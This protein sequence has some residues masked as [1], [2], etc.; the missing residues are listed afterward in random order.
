MLLIIHEIFKKNIQFLNLFLLR[1]F[2]SSCIT[3]SFHFNSLILPRVI[4]TNITKCPSIIIVIDSIGEYYIS[5]RL[6]L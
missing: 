3:S 5:E 4:S 1:L 2:I 6:S